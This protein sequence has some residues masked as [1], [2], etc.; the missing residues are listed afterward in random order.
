MSAPREIVLQNSFCLA[1]HRF[2]RPWARQSNIDVGDHF[3]LMNLPTTSVARLRL[4]IDGCRL[5][6]RLA[7]ILSHSVLGL[8][9]HNPG[10]NRRSCRHGPFSAWWIPLPISPVQ[11]SRL[12]MGRNPRA[13]GHRCLACGFAYPGRNTEARGA[14]THVLEL[15]PAFTITAYIARGGQSNSK[16]LIAGLRKASN[17]TNRAGLMM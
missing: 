10:V 2:S 4:S 1:D 16:L 13:A 3:I 6:C 9:Q 14:A 15:D 11:S 7:E 8:L 17:R 5:F 12:S